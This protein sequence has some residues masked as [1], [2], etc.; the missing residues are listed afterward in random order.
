MP[1]RPWKI[2]P[3]MYQRRLLLVAGGAV[4]MFTLPAL[5]VLNLTVAK[6]GELRA[7]ELQGRKGRCD[8]RGQRCSRGVAGGVGNHQPDHGAEDGDPCIHAGQHAERCG[9]ALAAVEAQEHREC[10]AKEGRQ[11]GAAAVV[12]VG[13]GLEG[14]AQPHLVGQNPPKPVALQIPQPAHPGLLRG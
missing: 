12:Q 11:A 4:L 3:S 5:Q 2:I 10:M 9:D 6:G 8:C 14:F 13:E 7:E 1:I